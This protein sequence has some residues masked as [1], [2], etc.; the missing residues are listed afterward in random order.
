MKQFDR[1]L[2]IALFLLTACAL[3]VQAQ[4]QIT[5]QIFSSPGVRR[6]LEYLKTIEPETI[7]DQIRACEIPSPTFQE[8]K[9]AE[10]FK[11]RFTELGL[12]N[13]RIDAIGKVIGERPGLGRGQ[14]LV[15]AAHLDQCFPEGS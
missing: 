10:H 4:S 8:Q 6:A 12:K 5:S 14:T 11:R 7:N 1:C 2:K 15:F 9:R 3:D 13:V